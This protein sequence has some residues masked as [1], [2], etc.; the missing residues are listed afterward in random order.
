M[1][2][3]K[4]EFPSTED[5]SKGGGNYY[6]QS[7]IQRRH[8]QSIQ[9]STHQI[10]YQ[11]VHFLFE[12][13]LVRQSSGSCKRRAYLWDVLEYPSGRFVNLKIL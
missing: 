11:F 4:V 9:A 7:E 6:K 13:L 3:R 12:A 1:S 5:T 10:W 2:R 8:S